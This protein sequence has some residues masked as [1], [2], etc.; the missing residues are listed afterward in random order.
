MKNL[1]STVA[2]A[3]LA[4]VM[5]TPVYAA[6]V[7]PMPAAASWTGFHVGVGGGGN[8]VFADDYANAFYNDVINILFSNSGEI[9]SDLDKAGAFAT[10]EIGADYQMNDIVFGA[11]ASYDFGKTTLGFESETFLN[12]NGDTSQTGTFDR[13]VEVGNS[14]AIGGRLGMLATDST[15]IY[16][17]GGFT[18]AKISQS[19]ELLDNS[20][21]SISGFSGANRESGYFVGAGVE[22]ML[23][24]SV[25]LKGEYRFTDFGSVGGDFANPNNDVNFS[26][27]VNQN[28]EVT[29]HSVRAV[30]SLRF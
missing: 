24:E 29:I 23:T 21:N 19:S 11:L 5:T 3:A 14:W 9:Y 20:N 7:E 18:Q 26:E 15:L 13:S 12:D 10:A 17:L 27:G 16:V 4:A 2:L 30:L 25:S 28:S 8:Y 22:T 6:G 1:N